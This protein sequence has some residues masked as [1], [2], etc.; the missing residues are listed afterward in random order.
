M[1]KSSIKVNDKDIAN[2]LQKQFV[3]TF[4]DEPD[5]ELPD[6]ET[7]TTK[8]ITS[9][10]ISSDK[11]RKKILRQVTDCLEDFREHTD[12]GYKFP[13][14]ARGHKMTLYFVALKP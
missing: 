1:S 7:R 4:T 13:R 12:A 14:F 9:V 2:I 6:F 10:T 8:N 5:G 3:S 11:V